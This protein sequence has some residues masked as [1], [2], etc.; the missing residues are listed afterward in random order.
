M[1][2]Y[3]V[4]QKYVTLGIILIFFVASLM[5]LHG[6]KTEDIAARPSFTGEILYVGGSGPNNYTKIQDAINDSNIGGTIYVYSDSSPYYEHLVLEKSISLI[7]E[8]AK[9]VDINGSLLGSSLDTINIT[10]NHVVVK[11]FYITGNPGYYYQAAV[12]VFGNNLTF[13]DC[14]IYGNEWVGISLVGT[15]FCKIRGCELYD[16]LIAFHLVESRSNTIENCVCHEN[17]DAISLF[18]NSHD[19]LLRNITCVRNSYSGIHIQQSSGNQIVGCLCEN[20]YDGIS[21]AFAAHT[22]MRNN[23]LRNNFANFGIGASSVSDFYCDI[24]TSNTIN[25]K[26]LYYLIEQNGLL[27]DETMEVGFL[28]LIR[29]SNISVKNCAFSTNFQGMALVGST[30]CLIENCRFFNNDGHGLYSISSW[31]NTVRN[32]TFQ[33]SF[34]AGIFLYGSFYNVIENCSYSD[35]SAGIRLEYSPYN[36]IQQQ[37]VDRCRIGMLFTSSGGNFLRENKLVFCGVKVDGDNLLHYI[38]DVDTSNTVNGKP[39][40]YYVNETNLTIP[41]DAG[42]VMLVNCSAC[43]VSNVTINHTSIAIELAYSSRNL[44]SQNILCC[45]NDAAIDLDGSDNNNN[46]IE[47]NIIRG[48]SYGIDVDSSQGTIIRGNILVDTGTGISFDSCLGSI[49][50]RNTIESCL[51]GMYFRSSGFNVVTD[52]LIINSSGFGLYLLSSDKNVLRSNEMINCG[53]MVY[54]NLLA[55]YLNDVDTSN[56]VN[57]KPLYYLMN[58]DGTTIPQDA[59]GVILV[60]STGCL[61]HDLILQSGTV[62]ITLAYSSNT[63]IRGNVIQNQRMTGID[64]SSGGNDNNIIQANTIRGNGYGIDIEYCTGNVMK[65]NLISLNDYGVFLFSAVDTLMKRN[66]FVKNYVGV[67]AIRS[68]ESVIRFNNIFLNSIYGLAADGCNVS[69]SWNWWGGLAGPKINEYGNGDRL[70]TIRDSHIL[71]APW[72]RLPVLFSGILR[73]LLTNRHQQTHTEQPYKIPKQPSFD[74]DDTFL[75]NP[76][77]HLGKIWGIEQD[78][79]VP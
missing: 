6:Q 74:H 19:N 42:G 68:Q 61:I 24:D 54:G 14:V 5:P 11:G 57:G 30:H 67:Y 32:C 78:R 41:S 13:S 29:C 15:S 38:N 22:T 39:M 1:K 43:T 17:A 34:F 44:I 7:G 59:G 16:N 3:P 77:I 58:H 40:Y 55:E 60:N 18:E 26:P 51:Y 56:T 69:A 70:Q 79:V 50:S 71:Y 33:N 21:L 63:I 27:F 37:T 72:L 10:G 36:T 66:S 64:L 20:G 52:N 73:Y 25:G 75:Q 46:I 28:G 23:T 31:G 47:N 48:N 8:D 45:N 12:K 9:R 62:G 76:A 4:I 53:L 35:S 65:Y 2:R 49:I